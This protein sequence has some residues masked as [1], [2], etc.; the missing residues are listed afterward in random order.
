MFLFLKNSARTGLVGSTHSLI[1]QKDERTEPKPL[2]NRIP[3]SK[4]G[5]YP[6]QPLSRITQRTEP[7]ASHNRGTG[8]QPL[9]NKE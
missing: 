7:T 3:S 1:P 8:F 6:R 9:R 5:F 2:K 4:M